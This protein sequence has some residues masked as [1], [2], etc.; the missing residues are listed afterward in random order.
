MEDRR[1]EDGVGPVR[2]DPGATAAEEPDGVGPHMSDVVSEPDVWVP[3]GTLEDLHFR[4]GFF[5]YGRLRP[6]STLETAGV[7][8]RTRLGTVESMNPNEREAAERTRVLSDNVVLVDRA[9]HCAVEL[10]QYATALV[11]AERFGSGLQ[12]NALS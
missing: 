4:G 9:M 3:A 1:E 8:L 12:R 6:E 10:G 7:Q 5:V 11:Y 2:S